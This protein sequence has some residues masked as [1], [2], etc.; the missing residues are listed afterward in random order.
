MDSIEVSDS[1]SNKLAKD[2]IGSIEDTGLDLS[3]CKVQVY[4]SA[5]NMGGIYTGVQSR[6]AAKELMAVYV[7]C[8]SHNLILTHNDSMKIHEVSTGR[9][10]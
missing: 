8:I 6:I 9:V 1:S 4:N 5:T 2:V 7:K 10:W 3:K